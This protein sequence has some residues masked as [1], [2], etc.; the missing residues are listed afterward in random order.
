ME[1]AQTNLEQLIV[2]TQAR[3]QRLSEKFMEKLIKDMLD[4]LTELQDVYNTAHR[5]LKP[6]NILLFVEGDE[7]DE[8]GSNVTIKLCDFGSSKSNYYY[9]FGIYLPTTYLTCHTRIFSS[10]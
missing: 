4:C 8:V 2:Q 1:R 9:F 6:S 7:M 10:K 5:D 3:S